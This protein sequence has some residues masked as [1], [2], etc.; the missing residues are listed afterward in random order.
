MSEAAS[1]EAD[2]LDTPEAGRK[3]VRGGSVRVV[4]FVFVTLLSVVGIALV[5]RY[6][7]PEKFGQFQTVLALVTIIQTI[8]DLGMTPLGIREFSQRKGRDRDDFMAV[9]LGL[10][11]ASTVV[12]VTLAVLV[13]LALGYDEVMVI[14]TALLGASVVLG[15]LQGTLGIPLMTQLRIGTVTALDLGRQT[16]L[17]AGYAA[18][19]VG[20]ASLIGFF[21]IS[22]PVQAAVVLATVVLV[23]GLISL[24]PSFDRRAWLALIKPS[25]VF[26]LAVAVGQVYV[27]TALV[28]TELV[29]SEFET[30]LFAAS[31]RVY[32]IVAAVP[33]ILVTTAFPLL[34]RAARDDRERLSYATQRLFE[35]TAILGGAA[36]LLCVLGAAPIIAIVAGPAFDE[37]VPVLQ[38]QGVA[39][40]MTFVIATWGFTLLA[41]HHHRP[42]IIANVIAMTV[43]A[44]TVV[45]LAAAHGA[46]GAALATVLGELVLAVGYAIALTS[47]DR[48]MRPGF[49]RVLRAVPALAIGLGA[50]LLLPA[51][52]VV[53]AAV[54]LGVYGVAL[55]AF[56]AVPDEILEHVPGPLGAAA[57]R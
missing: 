25:L 50:G 14:G 48:A 39:L 28:I 35:G 53:E 21:A 5:T 38:I 13:A 22:I 32:I 1:A 34:S 51:P 20:G 10:R 40:A 18:L 16:A 11:L 33:G 2:V 41:V 31:F 43:S 47:V 56:R 26:A 24:R 55:L 7:G 6:L 30:G 57:R 44:T 8:T 27:Y 46:T 3:I 42:M 17:T 37:A 54:G 15:L 9:L 29:T 19:V 23:R 45:V 12:G 36:L 52:A 4:G 49:G